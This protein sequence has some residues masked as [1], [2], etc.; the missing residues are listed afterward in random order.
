M[1]LRTTLMTLALSLQLPGCLGEGD[2]VEQEQVDQGQ[3]VESQE[4]ALEASSKNTA[5][6]KLLYEVRHSSTRV[7]RFW[8][9]FGDEL[10]VETMGKIDVDGMP[11]EEELRGEPLE[12]FARLNRGAPPA[13]LVEAVNR[14]KEAARKREA[15]HAARGTNSTQ[16]LG[17][18]DGNKPLARAA[19]LANEKVRDFKAVGWW[20]TTAC[21]FTGWPKCSHPDDVIKWCYNNPMTFVNSGAMF[22]DHWQAMYSGY[23]S[24]VTYKHWL[25]TCNDV[26]FGTKCNWNYD[27]QTVPVGYYATWNAT[28]LRARAGEISTPNN[29][30]SALFS[31]KADY[32]EPPPGWYF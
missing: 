16:E 26:V 19:S 6:R 30:G 25:E 20:T 22:A 5:N 21:N 18:S 9:L 24:S 17:S 14:S 4:A 32:Y 2:E 8:E 11:K 28:N 31:L 29:T 27:S 13:A 10:V 1:R 3:V 15:I 23:G 7:T 12:I